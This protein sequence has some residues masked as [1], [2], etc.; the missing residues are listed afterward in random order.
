MI[1]KKN[2]KSAPGKPRNSITLSPAET[3]VLRKIQSSIK[4][5]ELALRDLK[6]GLTELLKERYGIDLEKD[7]WTLDL[8][9]GTLIKDSQ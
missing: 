5:Q 8:D 6:Q 3:A 9:N 1:F 4:E 7:T 2:P